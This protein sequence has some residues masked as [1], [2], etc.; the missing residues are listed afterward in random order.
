MKNNRTKRT[1]RT[2]KN[3]G[4][5]IVRETNKDRKQ[6]GSLHIT[7]LLSLLCVCSLLLTG[8]GLGK[9]EPAPSPTPVPTPTPTPEPTPTPRP[10]PDGFDIAGKHYTIDDT[11]MDLTGLTEA[12][13]SVFTAVVPYMEYLTVVEL[14][15]E[16][17]S[18]VSWSVIAALQ[19]AA[20]QVEF[21]YSF[22]LYGESMDLQ[23][24][25]ID[26]RQISVDDNG[27]AVV[28]AL[29]CMKNCTYLDMDSCGVDD[30][31]MVEIR[32][33][34]PNVKVVWRVS[35]GTMDYSVRTDVKTIL[36][37]L[38][39]YG[40]YAGITND[41]SAIPLTYCTDVVNLDLGHNSN[42]R[43]TLFLQY[44][45]NL[46]V[47]ITYE[48]YLRDISDLVY[49][50]KLRYL[51]LYGN[52]FSD[53]SP[54]AELDNLTDLMLCAC[55]NVSDISPLLPAD[56]L[57]NLQRLYIAGTSYYIPAEQIEEFQR[58]HPN[59]EVNT[60]ENS[61]GDHWRFL[62]PGLGNSEANRTERYKEICNIFHYGADNQ[63]AYNFRRN[64]PY[65]TTPHGQPVV[66]KQVEWFYGRKDQS[67]LLPQ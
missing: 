35:F 7:V 9:A 34:F 44:M 12:D 61:V 39:G 16:T 65:A 57:P 50:K 63:E 22:S 30:A 62:D 32:D 5:D 38:S 53:V 6:N 60:T 49:C 19:N 37:S 48:N 8:C 33:A 36:A 20:P 26:L 45:P 46:E 4:T 58:N 55:Y 1:G 67:D 25:Y 54:I 21:R 11:S 51:E 2:D 28:A 56:V 42:M 47:F 43:T 10:Y 27:A 24:E 18:P 29:P 31:H 64:D 17:V 14:G 52:S 40:D 59:C 41:E 13:V 23:T 66:G 3:R 15:S